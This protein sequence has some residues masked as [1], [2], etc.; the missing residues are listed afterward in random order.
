MKDKC[1]KL[2]KIMMDYDTWIISRHLAGKLNVTERSI[3]SY[4]VEINNQENGLINSSRKGYLIDP[5]KARKVLDN[6]TFKLPQTSKERVNYIIIR[7]LTNNSTDACKVDLYQLGEEIFI[8]YET[9]KKDMVKV[10]KKLMAYDLYIASSDSEV[11]VEGKELDKRKILSH[12]L[13]EEFS[14]N[15]MSVKVIKKAFPNYN[16]ELVQSIIVEQCRQYHY[17]INEYALLSLVLD[18]IIGMDRIKMKRTFGKSRNEGNHFGIREQELTRKIAVEIEKAYGIH[19]SEIELEELTIILLS[20]LMEM[21]FASLTNDNIKKVVGEECVEIVDKIRCLL[22]DTY[23]IDTNNQD[24][25]VRFTLHIK[26]LLVRLEN[27]CTTKNPLLDQIKNTCPLI[28]ECAV[29]IADKLRG[30]TKQDI[31][32]DEIAYIAIHIGGSLETQRSKKRTIHCTILFPQYYDFSNRM[33]DKLKERYMNRIE[34][35]K[36]ITRVDDIKAI[37]KTDLIISTIPVFET[38]RTEWVMVNPFLND[39]DFEKIEEKIQKINLKKVKSR[40]KKHLMQISNPKFFFKNV[41]LRNKEE[42]IR[43]MANIMEKEGYVKESYYDEVLD[44]ENQASTAYEHIAVPHSMKMNAN[45]TGMFVLLNEKK[46]IMWDKHSVRV[47]LLFAINKEERAIFHDV[48]DNLIVLLLEK[49]NAIKVTESDS[50]IEFIEEV[51]KCF[52]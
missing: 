14:D 9:I 21:D 38:V 46:S 40:L 50:Y 3:K 34:I 31:S 33:M 11:L 28:F 30:I 10:R 17:Y 20:Y 51:V 29:D 25:I 35:K 22:M 48:F 4:I 27:G 8:S 45:R 5:I 16:I 41:N 36:I 18:I 42:A 23:F 13:Y 12:I 6:S 49:A 7:I 44:R 1:M 15:V 2:I 26:N 24:F 47:V 32:E 43:F 19:Y 39:K 52:H 37:E